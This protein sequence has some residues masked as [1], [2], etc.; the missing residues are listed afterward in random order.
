M[1]ENK[2]DRL[3]R[4][5]KVEHLLYQCPDGLTIDSIAEKCDV[6]TRTSRRD[7][8]A[9]EAIG[10]PIWEAGTRRGIAPGY[11]LP[12]I[13]FTLP[14][15]MTI[16]MAARLLLAYSNTYNPNID[17]TFVKLNSAVPPPLRDQVAT[18]IS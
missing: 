12:P 2:R 1:R 18:T 9:L 5:S 6:S 14:E 3:A 7:L 4:L 17:S 13:S 10:V 8:E 11:F 16:F 15:A